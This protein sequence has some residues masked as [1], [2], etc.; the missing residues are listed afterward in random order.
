MTRNLKPDFQDYSDPEVDLEED[1]AGLVVG[2]ASELDQ[3]LE[4][5]DLVVSSQFIFILKVLK[6][7]YHE[8]NHSST[9][10]L[11]Q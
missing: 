7:Q 3:D 4:E 1:L 5:P 2:M 6:G 10:N 9:F 11:N 8:K